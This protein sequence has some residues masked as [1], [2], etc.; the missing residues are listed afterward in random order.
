[1]TEMT[2]PRSLGTT[3]GQ[4]MAEVGAMSISNPRA[5][6]GASSQ[7]HSSAVRPRP[8]RENRTREG[9]VGL[10]DPPDRLLISEQAAALLGFRPNVL[11]AT[12]ACAVSPKALRL[13]ASPAAV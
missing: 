4:F 8:Y 10:L 2:T 7:R 11:I 3:L 12:R 6:R 1:M 13:S 9:R 5:S